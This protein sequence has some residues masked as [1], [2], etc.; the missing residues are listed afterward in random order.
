ME[1]DGARWSI[2]RESPTHVKFEIWKPSS[3]EA[4]ETRLKP[5]I[6]SNQFLNFR[7]IRFFFFFTQII[8]PFQL[9]RHADETRFESRRALKNYKR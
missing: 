5:R 2:V 7:L 6:F 4:L 9:V 3:L 1:R 8:V